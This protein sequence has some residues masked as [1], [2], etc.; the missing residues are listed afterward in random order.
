MILVVLGG[1][2]SNFL[3]FSSDSLWR[4]MTQQTLNMAYIVCQMCLSDIVS[5]QSDLPE[6]DLWQVLANKEKLSSNQ[7][8]V[9]D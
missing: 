6:L 1:S 3:P 4:L 2:S 8:I 7:L 9:I 5:W